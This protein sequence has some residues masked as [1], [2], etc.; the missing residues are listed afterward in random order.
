MKAESKVGGTIV[1]V[2]EGKARPLI[3]IVANLKRN[4]SSY[5][6]NLLTSQ[7]DIFIMH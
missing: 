3:E 2:F 7:I 5:G 1:T 4:S 6:I